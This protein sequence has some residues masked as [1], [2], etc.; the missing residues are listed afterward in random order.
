[1]MHGALNDGKGGDGL[2][3]MARL[4]ALNKIGSVSVSDS[5][6]VVRDADEVTLLLAASRYYIL[7]YPDY[8]GVIIKKLRRIAL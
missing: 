3:Y 6:V 8:K 4:S 2:Q 7:K 1:M 5:G